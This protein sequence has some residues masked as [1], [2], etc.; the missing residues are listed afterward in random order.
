MCKYKIKRSTFEYITGSQLRNI[1]IGNCKPSKIIN[2]SLPSF[3]LTNPIFLMK[4]NTYSSRP[5]EYIVTWKIILVQTNNNV[6]AKT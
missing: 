3:R 5:E 1:I 6:S 4:F 2:V